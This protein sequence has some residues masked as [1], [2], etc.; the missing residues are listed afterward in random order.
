MNRE[1]ER[2]EEMDRIEERLG[3]REAR[4]ASCEEDMLG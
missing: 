4:C 1:W 2:Y 3:I